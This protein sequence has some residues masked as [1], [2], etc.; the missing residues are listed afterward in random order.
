MLRRQV[1]LIWRVIE[2]GKSMAS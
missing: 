2:D 1:G